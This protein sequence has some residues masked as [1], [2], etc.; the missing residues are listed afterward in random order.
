M[1]K[2]IYDM[3]DLLEDAASMGE[4]LDQENERDLNG[5]KSELSSIDD[6]LD[7]V[8]ET[9]EG[10]LEKFKDEE[11]TMAEFKEVFEDL[12]PDIVGTIAKTRERLY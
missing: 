10:Y 1:T 3:L 6:E 5:M 9:L 11:L 12:L 4:E 8:T 7:E 2:S